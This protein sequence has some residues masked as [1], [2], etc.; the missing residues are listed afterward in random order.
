M[1]PTLFLDGFSTGTRRGQW[2]CILAS[3]DGKGVGYGRDEREG[4]A[5]EEC[6]EDYGGEARGPM[7]VLDK[8]DGKAFEEKEEDAVSKF[9]WRVIKTRTGSVPRRTMIVN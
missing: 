2:A 9:W 8:G 3:E 4:D 6:G 5:V 1:Q 7:M